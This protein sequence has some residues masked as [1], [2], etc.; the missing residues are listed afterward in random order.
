M[1]RRKEN[2]NLAPFGMFVILVITAA[3]VAGG[4]ALYAYYKNRQLTVQREIDRV[5]KRIQAHQLEVEATQM[6]IDEML[7][8]YA[9]REQLRAQG[10][11]LKAIPIGLIENVEGHQPVRTVAAVAP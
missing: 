11:A 2:A 9:L 6:R 7:N 1:N 8:R 3:L 5:E 4:G 10:S